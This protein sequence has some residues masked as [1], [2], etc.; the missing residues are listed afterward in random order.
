[1][2]YLKYHCDIF[3]LRFHNFISH[4][5]LIIKIKAIT[6]VDNIKNIT[7]PNCSH[8]FELEDVLARKLEEQ[9]K[10]EMDRFKKSLLDQYAH[11][12]E[13]LEKEK[14]QFEEKKRKENEIFKER[15]QK[16]MIEK[17]VDVKTKVREEYELQLKAQA[18]EL[19][20]KSKQVVALREKEIQLVRIQRKLEEQEKEIELKYQ[21]V[22]NQQLKEREE[23]IQKRIQEAMD[24]RIKEKDK[25]LE[26]QRK[27]IEEMKRK[28]DQGSMQMQGEVMEL[29]IEQVLA[30]AFP[31]DRIEEVP[32]G[33]RGAD[34]IQT[35]INNLLQECG[36]IIYESKRTKTFSDQWIQKLK[37]DQMEAS[38]D[39]AVLVTESMPKG[40][41]DFGEYNGIWL[42]TYPYLSNVAYVLRQM[43]IRVHNE[44]VAHE[45]KGEKIEV[46]YNYL[47]SVEFK[48]Q[49][50]SIFEGFVR[51]KEDLEK[52]KRSMKSIWKKREKQLELIMDNTIN[53]HG[54]IRGIA[55]NAIAPIDLLELPEGDEDDLD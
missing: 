14:L 7:C 33:I 42:C 5:P 23:S 39:L 41:E 8:T 48:N 37:Q 12:Q 52:E 28:A 34:S 43:L 26:D 40:M 24:M 17:E 20:E 1:M 25:Q 11:K 30:Q 44:R 29:A 47:T 3:I 19:E 10:V 22:L 49:F 9:S 46:L 13:A 32:K 4:K 50:T 36:K 51:M 55:G 38:A 21:Q 53:M 54:S 35:V 18:T 16:A 6:R 2:I 27:L 45:N 15:L 31:H